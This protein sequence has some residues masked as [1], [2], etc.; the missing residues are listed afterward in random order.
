MNCIITAIISRILLTIVDKFVF[1]IHEKFHFVF[2]TEEHLITILF[3]MS[4]SLNM[5]LI[6]NHINN[7]P[8]P[9]TTF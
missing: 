6:F 8:G 3:P 7:F 5:N 2:P 4:Y 9:L 1:I